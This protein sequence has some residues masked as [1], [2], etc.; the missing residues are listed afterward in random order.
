MKQS[1][2]SMGPISSGETSKQKNGKPQ[3]S[4]E[5]ESCLSSAGSLAKGWDV[6]GITAK[7]ALRR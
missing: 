3:H 4:E 5:S 2:S 6:R 1:L 7:A